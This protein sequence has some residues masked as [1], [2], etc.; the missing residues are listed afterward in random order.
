MITRVTWD[1]GKR[2][3]NL[4]LRGFDFAFASLVFQGPTL[5]RRDDRREYGEDRVIAVGEADG[6]LLWVVYTDR[7]TPGGVERRIISAR[8]SNQRERQA[9]Q[10]R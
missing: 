9:Y 1:P 5:E 7:P 8:R 6:F 2:D 4:S 10:D 3:A